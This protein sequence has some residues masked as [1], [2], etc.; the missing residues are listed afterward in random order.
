MASGPGMSQLVFDRPT[1][2]LG[3][4]HLETVEA[5]GFAGG[6]AVRGGRF[7]AQALSQQLLD[8]SWPSR[9]VISAGKLS[10][11]SGLLVV[12]TG[13]EIIAVKFVKAASR[14]G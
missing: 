4:I 12:S 3:S 1:A 11:P 9:S 14:N 10:G 5:E 6:K 2:H 13:F 8:F 7:A